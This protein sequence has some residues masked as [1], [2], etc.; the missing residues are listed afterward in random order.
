MTSQY[1]E[2]A[3]AA[4]QAGDIKSFPVLCSAF[5]ILS[6]GLGWEMSMWGGSTEDESTLLGLAAGNVVR[7]EQNRSQASGGASSKCRIRIVTSWQFTY[8]SA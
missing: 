1:A 7:M 2:E 3:V 8:F 4:P 5:R 6:A